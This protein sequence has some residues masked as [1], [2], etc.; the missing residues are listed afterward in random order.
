MSS[1]IKKLKNHT[2]FK[3]PKNLTDN[4]ISI[5]N[6]ATFCKDNT[7]KSKDEIRLLLT[8]NRAVKLYY[9]FKIYLISSYLCQK[10]SIL[11]FLFIIINVF[12]IKLHSRSIKTKLL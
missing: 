9:R 10:S 11:L 5:L 7:V 12:T 8:T 3:S 6:D 4:Q 2:I 1:A